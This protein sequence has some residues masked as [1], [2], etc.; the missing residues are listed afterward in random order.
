MNP[1]VEDCAG[2]LPGEP[3]A[4]EYAVVAVPTPVDRLFH[5]RIPPALRGEVR[6]GARVR[7]PFGHREILGF[8][9]G[10]ADTAPVADAQVREIVRLV[11]RAPILDGRMLELARWMAEYYCCSWGEA[12]E[13]MLPGAVKRPTSAD[14][15]LLVKAARA[16]EELRARAES[17][18]ARAPRQARV[19]RALAGTTGE[20]SARDLAALAQADYGV[21][22]TLE[23]AGDLR[24]RRVPAGKEP[25]LEFAVERAEPPPPTPEQA[26]ALACIERALARGGFHVILIHGVTGSGKTEIYIRALERVV[27][28]GRQG[29]VLVPEIALTPQTVARFKARFERVCILHSDLTDRRRRAQWRLIREGRADVVIGARSAV[30][31]PTPSL[32]LLVVDEEHEPSFKQQSVP[33]YHA[34]DVGIW[35]AR[36]EGALVILGSATPSLESY[37]NARSGKYELITLQHRVGNLPLPPVEILDMTAE[38]THGPAPLLSRRLSIAVE[39]ALA[40]NEQVILFLNRRGYHT[41]VVC[42]RCGFVLKCPRCDVSLTYH[43]GGHRAVC[44]YC[45]HEQGA[46][47]SCPGCNLPRLRYQGTG[48]QRIEEEIVRRFGREA[49]ARMDSDSMRGWGKYE[50]TLCRFRDGETR[51]LL[52]TQMVA[53]GHDFPNV[54]L[55]GVVNADVILDMPD[56][57]AAERT[58][59]LLAQ[60]AGRAGRGERGGR[61][62]IQ[63]LSPRHPCILF[64]RDHDYIRFAEHEL[65]SRKAHGYPP[66]SRLARVLVEGKDPAA[67]RARAE[68][69]ADRIRDLAAARGVQMLGPAEAPIGRIKGR[70]RWHLILKAGGVAALREVLGAI[71][72]RRAKGTQVIVDVDPVGML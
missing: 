34:R 6:V 22:R 37:H 57:R 52:G 32:G 69:V 63:T 21:I 36:Q 10:H 67:V 64:A 5:Y 61:V 56:F 54:T 66:F 38:A 13:G 14:T 46:P 42:P 68:E 65:R 17:V 43:R 39:S 47:E 45:G 58:F 25:S 59:Q 12:L 35:R 70:H 9:V 2:A 72:R 55:V 49:V 71:D 24:L 44:H 50:E 31:A 62:M 7:V 27:A 8:C 4:P 1:E 53:K 28:S 16:P 19:L 30:F 3:S 41:R 23:R 18:S 20:I 40:G 33:R 11:D 15:V 51:I 48:T 26:A 29:I 60:V